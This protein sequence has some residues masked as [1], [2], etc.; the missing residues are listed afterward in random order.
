MGTNELQS[1]QHGQGST[2][3][4]GA[5]QDQPGQHKHQLHRDY[6]V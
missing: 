6:P 4:G 2:S 1:P 3:A 5:A